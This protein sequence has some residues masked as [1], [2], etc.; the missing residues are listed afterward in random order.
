MK[1]INSMHFI[2]SEFFQTKKM[3][4]LTILE[5]VLMTKVLLIT[6]QF[7]LQHVFITYLRVFAVHLNV[8]VIVTHTLLK[9]DCESKLL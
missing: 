2:K 7:T 8:F 3:N 9:T 6:D 4:E 5:W 1:L